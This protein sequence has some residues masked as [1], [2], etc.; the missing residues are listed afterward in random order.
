MGLLAASIKICPNCLHKCGTGLT[1]CLKCKYAF[2]GQ[3]VGNQPPIIMNIEGRKPEQAEADRLSAIPFPRKPPTAY[4]KKRILLYLVIGIIGFPICIAGILLTWRGGPI[5]AGSFVIGAIVTIC[6][7]IYGFVMLLSDARK[8]TS[9][10]AFKWIWRNIYLEDTDISKDAKR[11]VDSRLINE[12]SIFMRV[13]PDDVAKSIDKRS[14][15]NNLFEMRKTLKETLERNGEKQ[16][17]TCIMSGKEKY[18]GTWASGNI[19]IVVQN[20]EEREVSPNVTEITS[21][22]LLKKYYDTKCG[23]EYCIEVSSVML[24]VHEFYIKNGNYCFPYDML[25]KIKV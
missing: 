14:W 23:E 20:V 24:N 17:L 19:T 2:T 15:T 21:S 11:D 13:I 16:D 9:K 4:E 1:F 3:E 12:H 22:I 8:K 10:E 5:V 25:H 7:P 18:T 6:L